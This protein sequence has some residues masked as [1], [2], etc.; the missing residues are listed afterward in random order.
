MDVM[1]TQ[2]WLNA[3]HFQFLVL[4]PSYLFFLRDAPIL[5]FV[6]G[7][8]KIQS[9]SLL[10]AV[11][12]GCREIKWIYASNPD[13]LGRMRGTWFRHEHVK[14]GRAQHHALSS[15]QVLQ[16]QPP[17]FE[18]T[19]GARVGVIWPQYIQEQN[20]ATLTVDSHAEEWE[21]C[22]QPSLTLPNSPLLTG[23]QTSLGICLGHLGFFLKISPNQGC[24]YHGNPW[25]APQSK[26]SVALNMDKWHSMWKEMCLKLD[27][28]RV[29][30]LWLLLSNLGNLLKLF[31]M[32]LLN[33]EVQL[34]YI[35]H[36]DIKVK[37]NTFW[38]I[39]TIQQML[40]CVSFFLLGDHHTYM[41][42]EQ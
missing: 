22:W 12:R 27:R 28:K 32:F 29:W 14:E 2:K 18:L 16:W 40:K 39:P 6:L 19:L 8:L 11:S 42:A 5:F 13:F 36:L 31:R 37:W 21:D 7:S 38:M 34:L 1:K 20:R 4:L 25:G 41:R 26:Q 30:D 3:E 10:H 35:P 9:A 23:K 15:P 24:P 33:C 17:S